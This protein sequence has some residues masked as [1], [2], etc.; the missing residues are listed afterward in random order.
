MLY[1]ITFLVLLINVTVYDQ[2]FQM[3]LY[4]EIRHFFPISMIYLFYNQKFVPPSLLQLF[5]PFPTPSPLATH[6]FV[7][8]T[9]ESIF[10]L[11]L[12][13]HFFS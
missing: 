12:L 6:Q 2:E 4:I 9:D 8:C 3:R 10:V 7:L 1:W 5:L 11:L 13:V